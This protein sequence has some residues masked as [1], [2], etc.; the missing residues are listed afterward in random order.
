MASNTLPTYKEAGA[1]RLSFG[2]SSQESDDG[3]SDGVRLSLSV[4]SVQESDGNTSESQSHHSQPSPPQDAVVVNSSSGDNNDQ[5][6]QP[7]I[8]VV[9]LTPPSPNEQQA[10]AMAPVPTDGESVTS[11]GTP[12]SSPL[13]DVYRGVRCVLPTRA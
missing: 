8:V 1:R 6:T 13:S 7:V 2:L 9:S 10:A 3:N 11:S 12:T 5:N 4:S